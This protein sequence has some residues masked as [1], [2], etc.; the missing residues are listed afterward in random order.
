MNFITIVTFHALEKPI[1]SF[2]NIEDG[3]NLVSNLSWNST[4]Y[5]CFTKMHD[6]FNIN[7]FQLDI[8]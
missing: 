3:T 7:H 5:G 1:K 8:M 4:V 2:F 6:L